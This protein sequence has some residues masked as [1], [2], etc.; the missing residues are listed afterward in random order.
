MIAVLGTTLPV[1]IGVTVFLAG[2]AAFMTGQA[3]ASHW[4]PVWHVILYIALLGL[5]DRFITFALFDGELLSLSGYAID[6]AVL[7]AIGLFS[8]R[9]TRARQMV[10]QYPW[11][12][13]PAGLL[14]WRDKERS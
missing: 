3:L 14:G 11:L 6:T 13:E 10:E 2:G 5:A 9:L 4:R 12:Y 1:F 8:Y 7:Q